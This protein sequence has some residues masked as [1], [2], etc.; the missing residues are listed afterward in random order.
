MLK[1][2]IDSSKYLEGGKYYFLFEQGIK[3]DKCGIYI[4]QLNKIKRNIKR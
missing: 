4:N 3:Y 2:G 1:I